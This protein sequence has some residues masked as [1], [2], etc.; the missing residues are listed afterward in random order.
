MIEV[1]YIGKGLAT[2]GSAIVCSAWV[3]MTQGKSGIGW[4]VLTLFLIW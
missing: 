2:I 1:C 4:F 3:Y